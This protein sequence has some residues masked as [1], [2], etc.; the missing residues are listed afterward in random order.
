MTAAGSHIAEQGRAELIA[1][2]EN[3]ST[4]AGASL[5]SQ[6]LAARLRQQLPA[7]ESLGSV[8]HQR[9][10]FDV[11]QGAY[12]YMRFCLVTM[13]QT[14]SGQARCWAQAVA[15]LGMVEGIR[16]SATHLSLLPHHV[17]LHNTLRLSA[18]W[19]QADC[20]SRGRI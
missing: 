16:A 7:A 14:N 1:L 6:D 15:A 5:V 12:P 10:G 17:V 9:S 8:L 3:L 4:A 13:V 19:L 20:G 18:L 2:A 11:R